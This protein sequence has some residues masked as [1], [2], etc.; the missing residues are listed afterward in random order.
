M[1]TAPIF[2]RMILNNINEGVYFLDN[3]RRITFWNKGAETI[4]GISP[5]ARARAFSGALARRSSVTL[6]EIRAS[7]S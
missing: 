5:I 6:P 4:Y 1:E 7:P 2:Y 3:N